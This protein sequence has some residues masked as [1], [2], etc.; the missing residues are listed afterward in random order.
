M[1][2]CYCCCRVVAEL[3][4]QYVPVP[5]NIDTVNLVLHQNISTPA[6]MRRWLDATQIKTS[7][8]VNGEDAALS[9][10]G[11]TLYE[12]IFKPYT[13]KQWSKY[14]HQLNAS[15]LLRIPVAR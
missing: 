1:N 5:V 14:P 6:Q 3:D 15:V 10:V 11:R 9:R 8:L 13:Y 2:C 4:G 7:H 12:K